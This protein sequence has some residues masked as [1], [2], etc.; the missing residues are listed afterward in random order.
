MAAV[1]PGLLAALGT[2]FIAG[3]LA[4]AP[5]GTVLR[6]G[7][8]HELKAPSAAAKIARDGDTV[9]IDAGTYA[10]DAA[11]WRQ[12]NLTIRA[13][14][15]RAHMRADGAHAEGKGIW[16]LKGSNTTIE[17]IEFSGAKVSHRNGAAIRLEGPG[18]TVRNCYI[19]HNENGILTGGNRD[20]DVVI[21][22]SELSFNG[23]GDGLSHNLYIGNVRTF[24][25]R[26]SYVHRAL[27]GH[28]VKSRAIKNYIAYNRI[29]DEKDG[30][31][32][33]SIDLPD[34]GLSFVIGNLIQQGPA[35]ENRTIVSYGAEG[36]KN[37]L[38]D[39]YFVHN[40]VVNDDPG[41]GRFIFIKTGADVAQ[42]INNLFAGPGD[43]VVGRADMRNNAR[44]SKRDFLDEHNFDYRLRAGASAIGK[45]ADPGSAYGFALRP[46]AE[47]VHKAQ[48]R[49]RAETAAFDLGGLQYSQAK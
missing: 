5:S 37:P 48:K 46:T 49:P 41:G 36:Y 1:L 44:A 24:T 29:M 42:V 12:S 6:V 16:V 9:E 3:G 15:G 43:L 28:N 34:G 30:R 14:G 23:H 40:T 10:G 35:T 7:A 22:H 33:Y 39:L 25:L 13:V 38:N 4:A 26:Y 8:G 19:H 21:E 11:V 31:S 47:Y 17:G 32:S 2:L 45:G 20:S 18:L 27:V